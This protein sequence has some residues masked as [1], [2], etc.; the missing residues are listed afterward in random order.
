MFFFSPLNT[1]LLRDF[2]RDVSFS[3]IFRDRRK[4]SPSDLRTAHIGC[5]LNIDQ[6]GSWPSTHC[7]VRSDVNDFR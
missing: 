6:E 2:G 1:F 5:N 3:A 4:E 7:R